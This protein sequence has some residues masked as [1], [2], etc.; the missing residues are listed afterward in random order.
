MSTDFKDIMSQRTDE[1]LIKI[2][3]LDREGYQPLAVAAAEAELTSRN[4]DSAE[5]ERVE[6]E[7]K[8]NVKEAQTIDDETVGTLLRVV[9]FVVDSIVWLLIAFVLTL[10]LD[11]MVQFELLI[12]YA[13]LFVSFIGY[14]F[15]MEMYCQRT[16]AK[17]ITRTKVVTDSGDKPTVS[18]ILARTF[19]RLIP[20]D[21]ISF[22]FIRNGFHDK[23][24]GTR[25]VKVHNNISNLK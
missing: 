11:A 25:V 18:D 2:V 7:L 16:V 3:T 20:F 22:L 13:I 17:F 1:Q 14:Y 15:V 10:P 8:I 4:I 12:G 24:S 6:N 19:C 21:Q 9:H 5:F 23:L